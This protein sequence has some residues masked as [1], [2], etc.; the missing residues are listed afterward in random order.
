MHP[1]LFIC[2]RALFWIHI[3]YIVHGVPP[4]ST[5]VL[6]LLI[7]II[8]VRRVS[9]CFSLVNLLESLAF[10]GETRCVNPKRSR[11]VSCITSAYIQVDSIMGALQRAS[12]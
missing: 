11:T 6:A 10:T 8:L 9:G 12:A 2:L 3:F 1:R 7:L 5:R 4:T